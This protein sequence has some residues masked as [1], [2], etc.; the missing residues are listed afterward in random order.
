MQSR[1][2]E[3]LLGLILF[4]LTLLLFWDTL[5]AAHVEMEAALNPVWY[6]RVL[7]V[8]SGIA[9]A[10]L[11]L[12]GVVGPGMTWPH[13]NYT[14]LGQ[15]TAIIAVYFGIF[16][17]VGIL[18][19]T[20]VLIPALALVLGYRRIGLTLVVSALFSIGVWYLFAD[21]FVVRPPGIGVDDL[22]QMLK[23]K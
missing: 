21:G 2:P 4:G 16:N 8:L 7:L 22:F 1:A 3:I 12:R 10:G 9:S 19:T 6:P 11:L 15:V 5:S 17:D 14:R 18:L 23:G 13:P 20:F